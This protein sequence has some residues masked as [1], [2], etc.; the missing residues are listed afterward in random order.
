MRALL[1]AFALLLALGACRSEGS[2]A[3]V[4][5]PGDRVICIC[6]SSGRE[7]TQT[8]R[9]DGTGYTNCECTRVSPDVA[10]DADPP[11]VVDDVA[12]EPD[13]EEEPEADGSGD[14]AD[15]AEDIED[16][17]DV[18]EDIEDE[19]DAPEDVEDE[20]DAPADIEDE[21]EVIEDVEDEPDAPPDTGLPSALGEPCVADGDCAEGFCLGF[22]LS[23]V[24]T[25][26]CSKTCCHEALDCPPG[27]GCLQLGGGT[28]CLPA[29]I[30]PL[31]ITFGGAV[32]QACSA[33]GQC[34][35]DIC[36][37]E[38][39]C[40][41]SCCTDADCTTTCRFIGAGSRYR[42]YCD[43]IGLV[44]GGDGAPCSAGEIDCASGICLP[45]AA[46]PFGGFCSS[47]CCRSA[48][49]GGGRICGLIA[50]VGGSVARAC[51]PAT[52]GTVPDG[53]TCASDAECINDQCVNGVCRS[54]CCGDAD[55]SPLQ[56]CA[57][58][59]TAFGIRT[60]FCIDR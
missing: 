39:G 42:T 59:D 17:P 2:T 22:Q 50:G 4:C 9:D 48:Q 7:G 31:G 1:L 29:N 40:R 36:D 15:V 19:P 33:G 60:T 47:L 52:A 56:Y 45:D 5:D 35:S 20:P 6:A 27:F 8:C 32:G 12:D 26:V 28:Y 46:S 3:D 57:P 58:L 24:E 21:P 43:S 23:G 16:E 30:F 38:R 53:R 25:R 41:G 49:C 44:L 13:I 11:D 51:V 14:A 55:C 34:Q 54:V 10:T 18:A 37:V